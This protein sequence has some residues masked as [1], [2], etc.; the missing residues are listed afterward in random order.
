MSWNIG[1]EAGGVGTL[2]GT[3]AQ[4]IGFPLRDV[5]EAGVTSYS[6]RATGTGSVA[7]DVNANNFTGQF[8]SV[9]TAWNPLPSDVA[10]VVHNNIAYSYAGPRNVLIGLGGTYTAVATDFVAVGTADH[11]LL[12]NRTAADA[13]SIASITGLVAQQAAQDAALV[14]HDANVNAHPEVRERLNNNS[15]G[16]N[17]VKVAAIKFNGSGTSLNSANVTNLR[18]TTGTSEWAVD[19]VQTTVDGISVL[20]SSYLG[21]SLTRSAP[22]A[23]SV[24]FPQVLFSGITLTVTLTTLRTQGSVRIEP[25]NMQ[26]GDTCFLVAQANIPVQVDQIPV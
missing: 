14:T 7:S 4:G 26:A 16:W 17:W 11:T 24:V 3:M 20:P 8:H 18:A 5:R 13:H 15:I 1:G 6:V 9:G 25:Y 12:V 2:F 22:E 23:G 19:V 10:T 21:A